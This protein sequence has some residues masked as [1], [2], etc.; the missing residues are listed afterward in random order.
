MQT[1]ESS[2]F[3]IK[4]PRTKGFRQART[5]DELTDVRFARRVRDTG[6]TLGGLFREVEDAGENEQIINVYARESL[7]LE[8]SKSAV[9]ITIGRSQ[10]WVDKTIRR[11]RPQDLTEVAEIDESIESLR[12]QLRELKQ[13]RRFTLESAWKRAAKVPLREVV[14]KI[15]A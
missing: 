6:R 10:D 3:I 2:T 4:P 13:R 14:D 8:G 1:Q 11:L 15:P 5:A 7:T 9:R 12:Q